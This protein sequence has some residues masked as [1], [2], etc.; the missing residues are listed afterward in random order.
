[1]LNIYYGSENIDREKFI[2]ENIKGR[3]LLLVPDQFSLQAERDAFFY[4]GKKGLM[5]LSVVD[6]SSLGSKVIRETDGELPDMIDK[7][8]RHML[9]SRII[10]K[11]GER[12]GIY[13]GLK[14]KDSFAEMVNGFISEM[15]RADIVPDMLEDVRDSLEESSLLK[16]KLDDLLM[17]YREYENEIKDKYTD[18]EDYIAF[19]GKRILSSDL[20]ASSDVWIYGFDTFTPKNFL[21]MERILKTAGNLNVVMTYSDDVYSDKACM[22]AD[23]SGEMFSLTQHIIEKLMLTAEELNEDVRKISLEKSEKYHRKNVWQSDKPV[24]L[25]DTSNIYAEADKA[26]AYIL[27]LVRD[28]GYRFRDIAVICNDT[29]VRT[30]VLRR[31]FIRWGIPVFVDK[32]RKILHH[33]AVGFILALMEAASFGYRSESMMKLMKSG[34]MGFEEDKTEAL[35]NYIQQFRVRGEAWKKPFFREGESYTEQD[36]EKL[37]DMRLVM[38]DLI[39]NVKESIGRYN[40][41]EEKIKGLYKFLSESFRMP[42]RIDEMM[43]VQS[44]QGLEEGAAETAQSWNAVCDIFDQITEIAGEDRVSNKELLNLLEAGLSE[45]EIGLVP[46][47][48]DTVIIGTMQRTR[49]S[50]IKAVL[51]VG[52][53]EGIFPL[54]DSDEGLLNEKEKNVLESFDLE[55]VKSD[56]VMRRE[57]RLAIYRIL[58]LP[59]EKL[60]MSFSRTDEKGEDSNPSEIFRKLS[61]DIKTEGDLGEKDPMEMITSAAGTL[62]Y[63]ADAFRNC[64]D[65]GEIDDIWLETARWYKANDADGFGR[66]AKGMMFDNSAASLGEKFADALYRGD[67]ERMEVSASRLEKYSSCPFS[68][69]ILYGLHPDEARVFEMGARETGDVYHECIM[70]L[71]QKYTKG[72]PFSWATVT[73]EQCLKDVR[74]IIEAEAGNYREGLLKYGKNEKYRTERII[75]ICSEAVWSLVKQVRKGNIKDMYFER[76]FGVGKSLPPVKVDVGGKE[77]VI[78]GKIDRMDV[79]DTGD[80]APDAGGAVR[81]VD[82]KTGGDSVDVE[83]FR[84]GYKLQLMVYMKA[85]SGEKEKPAGVFLFKIHEPDVDADARSVKIGEEEARKRIEDSYRMEWIVVNDPDMIEA[86]DKELEEKSSVIPI[87]K[88]RKTGEYAPSAGGYLFTGEEFD[89]LSHQV[90]VQLERICREIYDGNIDIRPK[91]ESV[92]DMDGKYKNACKYCGYKSICMFDT[93]FKGCGFEQV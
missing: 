49:I 39:E 91:R 23:E 80:E 33:P 84:K 62:S 53:N 74:E 40:T 6:F 65:D 1:M 93:A 37:N 19:Y 48:S 85:A 14:D 77:V 13:R 28:E 57:E 75:D 43:S 25:A 86:M 35:E 9:L 61:A 4:L 12:L 47:T 72:D 52:A 45:V 34:F 89:E 55:M 60:Y 38:T 56:E 66:I 17:I 36:L 44:R 79:L 16:H 82:Y 21:V 50:R 27:K 2:F 15:K 78:R 70:K 41:A 83:Y 29:S 32:K 59:S 18:S 76:S 8:G 58:S 10:R 81:I 42:E 69:F 30:G 7:Y 26:A 90:D 22:L 31:T 63:I 73:E 88:V 87:K 24:I 54:D 68:H 67:R 20:V 3:T 51:I 46:V 64:M 71:S 92:K 11:N 5:D